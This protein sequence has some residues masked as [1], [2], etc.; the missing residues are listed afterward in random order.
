MDT[1]TFELTISLLANGRYSVEARFTALQHNERVATTIALDHKELNGLV[2]N[3]EAY[4]AALTAQLFADQHLRDSWLQARALAMSGGALAVRLRLDPF[5]VSLHTLRW[6]TL[7]DPLDDQ[8]LALSQR[9]YLART[10]DGGAGFS[11]LPLVPRPSVLR[12]LVVVAAP[13]DLDQYN[14]P[15]IDADGELARA[16][17]ALGDL[18]LTILGDAPGA[19]GRATLE[20][21]QAAL[22]NGPQ[23]V[24]LIAHSATR[25]GQPVLYLE[26]ADGRTV[27]TFGSDLVAAMQRQAQ[28]P[29]LLVLVSCKSAGDDYAA[30]TAVGPRLAQHG[31]P[32]VIAFQGDIAMRATKLL[33]PRLISEAVKDGQIDRALAAARAALGLDGPWWQPV[34]FLRGDGRLWAEEQNEYQPSSAINNHAPNWG[35]QGVFHGPVTFNQSSVAV[36]GS[37]DGK[38]DAAET[39]VTSPGLVRYTFDK[40]APA[41][42]QFL[43]NIGTLPEPT[44]LKEIKKYLRDVSARIKNDLREK[45]Y[46][47]LEGKPVLSNPLIEEV[48]S[49]PFV[50]PIHQKMLH[51]IGRA[52][53]GDSASAQIA[54]VNRRSRVVRNIIKLL[55]HVEDP[56]V[57]LG[58]PG[59]GKTM[60]LQ[61]SAMLIAESEGNRVFPRLPIYVRLGEF[62]IGG[63]VTENDVREYVKQAVPPVIRKRFDALDIIGNK[64][65]HVVAG[66]GAG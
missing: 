35:A 47:P 62:H 22:S 53:G 25:A 66:A 10:L 33:L 17:A 32:A 61:Q 3:P 65:G 44:E 31:L 59:S 12:A 20:A 27:P 57:L 19:A 64:G 14:L 37:S 9:V 15:A 55:D 45:T 1:P 52:L 6:E 8:P 2:F 11:P 26:G 4:G 42:H 58:E 21:T 5:D 60:T 50:S 54:A 23:I 16:R 36:G 28:R 24:I 38:D 48:S 39:L 46:L 18:P 63:V 51:L 40:Y 7:R 30:L 56:I 43:T 49:D 13:T 41:L 34:L 29:L